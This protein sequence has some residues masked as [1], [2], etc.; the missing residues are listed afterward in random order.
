MTTP[1]GQP[2]PNGQD[3]PDDTDIQIVFDDG[4]WDLTVR[5]RRPEIPKDWPRPQL[6]PRETPP[7]KP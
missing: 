2:E 3:K 7:E 6:P 5:P 1:S 4:P